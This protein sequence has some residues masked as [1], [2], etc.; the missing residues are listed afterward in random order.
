MLRRFASKGPQRLAASEPSG[1][2]ARPQPL[3][4]LG[5]RAAPGAAAEGLG[6]PERLG[7]DGA[8]FGSVWAMSPKGKLLEKAAVFD[9]S[10]WS[11]LLFANRFFVN[12]WRFSRPFQVIL[13]GVF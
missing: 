3:R 11:C 5:A 1:R 12:I 10:F 9:M 4:W 8:S 7:A 2:A 13:L 6:G